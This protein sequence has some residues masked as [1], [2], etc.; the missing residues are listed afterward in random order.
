MTA[1]ATPI[2]AGWSSVKYGAMVIAFR[3]LGDEDGYEWAVYA[4]NIDVSELIELGGFTEQLPPPM[5]DVVQAAI[6]RQSEQDRADGADD[7]LIGDIGGMPMPSH[8]L[9]ELDARV[10]A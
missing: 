8:Y 6:E 9:D 1:P 10:T 3:D 5:D 4:G 7:D 2:P